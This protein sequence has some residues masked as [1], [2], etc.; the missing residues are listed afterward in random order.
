MADLPFSTS[1]VEPVKL[2]IGEGF[3]GLEPKTTVEVF[4][5]IV[6]KYG[7]KPCMHQKR[8]VSVAQHCGLM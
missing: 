6:A 5:A 2:R 3:A 8:A 4:D 1:K 7:D